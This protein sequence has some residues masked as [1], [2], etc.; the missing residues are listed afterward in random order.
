MDSPPGPA[1]EARMTAYIKRIATGPRM[2]KDLT[3]AQAQDGMGLILSQSVSDVQTAVFLVALRMKRETDA[4]NFGVLTAL[5]EAT[6]YAESSVPELVDLAD[7]Y[8]GFLRALPVSSFLPALLAA[9]GLPTVLHG[10]EQVGPKFGVTHRQILAAAGVPVNLTPQ[11]AALR[12]S[13]PKIGWAYVDQSLF[14]PALHRLTE[15]RRLM[16]KR[17][18]L[19][20]LEKLCGPVRAQKNH[21]VV[22]FVHQDYERL[23]PEAARYAGYRSAVVIRGV[24]GGVVA[25][26]NGAASV[27]LYVEGGETHALSLD[28]QE[29]GV[30]STL[31]SVPLPAHLPV[32]VDARSALRAAGVDAGLAALSGASG[33]A[34]DALVYSAASILY[35]LGRF[36]ALRE[37]AAAVC[38]AL[39]SG[40]TR[41][42]FS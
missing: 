40:A 38:R 18:C 39:D 33:P 26:L 7:P 32:S 14:C 23:L 22:G 1:A 11:E 37:A 8:D 27:R 30:V 5:R 36:G 16:V 3:L 20:T 2:S 6:R 19:S 10:C 9:C 34:R 17:P 12:L 21:L 15:V 13:D 25:P 41:A 28:P 31:R 24:E 35:A 42:H 29:A 4:E